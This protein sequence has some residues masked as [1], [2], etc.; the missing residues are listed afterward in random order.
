LPPGAAAHSP[1][2]R[3]AGCPSSAPSVSAYE[4][5][6]PSPHP[7][8]EAFSLRDHERHLGG[9]HRIALIA[10]GENELGVPL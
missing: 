9:A 3:G 8:F 10:A 1:A 2:T 5:K 6:L 4:P 7:F